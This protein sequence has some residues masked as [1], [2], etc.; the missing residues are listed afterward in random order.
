MKNILIPYDFSE[1]AINALNY[2]KK[3][4]E[5][6]KINIFL[7][8]VYIG[9]KPNLIS[10]EK[11]KAWFNEMDNDIE[12]E[13]SYL[14][15][16][17]NNE[18]N[19]FVYNAIVDANSLIGAVKDVINEEKIDLIISGTK[20]AKS[21]AETFIGTNTL[22]IVN[23]IYTVPIIVVPASFKYKSLHHIVFS[24]NY[25]R[26][27]KKEELE[28]LLTIAANK[29]SSIEVVN[30]SEE[31][32]LTD[33]QKQ[34]RSQLQSLLANY[35]NEFFKLDWE[36]SETTTIQSYIQET[37]KNLLALINHKY[38]FF[39]RLSQENVIKKATFNSGF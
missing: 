34:N 2:T 26:K 12:D 31:T 32:L 16:G 27:T 39:Y 18:D 1:A 23:N 17:L 25:K 11:S 3:L 38:N 8:D 14:I 36:E 13:L 22:K 15:N 10:E 30:L 35:D 20:G 33:K 6:K 5:G 21:V 19:G 4:F 24:T 7:L 37:E 28:A 9:K 29:N